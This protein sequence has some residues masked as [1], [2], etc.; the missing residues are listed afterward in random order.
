[1]KLSSSDIAEAALVLRA[2]GWLSRTPPEF[3]DAVLDRCVWQNV[4]AGTSLTHGGDRAG[5]MYGI[6]CGV[7]GITP[8]V[9]PAD[10][11]LINVV[12]APYW[13][14]ILPVVSNAPRAVS[15]TARSQC[16]TAVVPQPALAA[17][18]AARPEWWQLMAM[19]ALEHFG[20]AA[21]IA[22]DLLIA[23]SRRRCIAVLL[24]AAG[25]RSGGAAT[26]DAGISQAELAAMA[27]MSRQTTSIVLRDLAA[28]QL[29]ALGYRGIAI[30]D[31]AALRACV[32]I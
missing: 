7:I 19:Q 18:L 9:G 2:R 10:L 27:N 1:V 8:A 30:R 3:Q 13:F 25:C 5:A 12:H 31:A 26:G 11:P 24:R 14:G 15:V 32:D 21:Q 16:L 20:A 6:A 28:Q 17:L 23:D 29:I 22:S 4:D